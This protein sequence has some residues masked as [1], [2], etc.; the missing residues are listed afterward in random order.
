M[1]EDGLP[2]VT[3]VLPAPD[4]NTP[5]EEARVKYHTGACDGIT[6]K[7]YFVESR[8]LIHNNAFDRPDQKTTLEVVYR[9]CRNES[10]G[11]LKTVGCRKR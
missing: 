4:I 7:G 8:N 9:P 5:S 11:P 3:G 1:S 10:T 2:R 6:L